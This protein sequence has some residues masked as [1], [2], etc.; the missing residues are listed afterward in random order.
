MIESYLNQSVT[1]K[2][3]TGFDV[4]GKPTLSTGA[5]IAARFQHKTK[6][7][8]NDQGLEYIVDAELWVKPDQ[9]IA[10]EDVITYE[11]ANYKVVKIDDKRNLSGQTSHKKALLT[12]T[13][14]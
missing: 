5:A 9:A 10:L 14:E 12:R 11:S 4:A 3:K 6:T 1:I 13:K 7:M 2:S 8:R